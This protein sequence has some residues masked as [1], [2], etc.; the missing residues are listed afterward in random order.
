MFLL[1]LLQ[2]TDFRRK[3]DQF[4]HILRFPFF[5]ET[6]RQPHNRKH[7]SAVRATGKVWQETLVGSK[8]VATITANVGT[9]ATHPPT[10][11][12]R[13]G[14]ILKGGS[15]ESGRYKY[16]RDNSCVCISDSRAWLL[17]AKYLL[18]APERNC[19]S[20]SPQKREN[21]LT[22]QH[23]EGGRQQGQAL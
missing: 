8:I 23:L 10:R 17:R 12:L 7:N 2:K 22:W 1:L 11:A 4:C 14:E 13:R 19:G 3:D 16:K 21:E 20:S 15:Q 6:N 18:P 5:T 9:P